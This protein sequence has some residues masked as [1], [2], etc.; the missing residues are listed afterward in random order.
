MI[1]DPQRGW[2]VSPGW[3]H[4]FAHLEAA[5]SI[6]PPGHEYTMVWTIRDF[7]TGDYFTVGTAPT[8]VYP[9]EQAAHAALAALRQTPLLP[10][11][12]PKGESTPS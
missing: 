12:N 2:R 9:T 5:G 10:V 3:R 11:A 8:L 4:Q 6:L 7:Y 1:H